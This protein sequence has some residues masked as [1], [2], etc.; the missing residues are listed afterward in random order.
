MP[1][2]GI[3][4]RLERCL[5]LPALGGCHAQQPQ[6]HIVGWGVFGVGLEACPLEPLGLVG[7]AVGG[8][9]LVT[10]SRDG[11][12]V[13]VDAILER[14]PALGFALPSVPEA[15]GHGE[16][17]LLERVRTAFLRRLGVLCGADYEVE[18]SGLALGGVF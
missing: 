14:A 2:A 13:D 3:G 11:V 5:A 16:A 1:A 6:H 12:A 7:L 15:P 9:Y 18:R 8:G 4:H 10:G 17:G